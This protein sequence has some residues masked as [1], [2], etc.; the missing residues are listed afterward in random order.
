MPIDSVTPQRGS[1]DAMKSLFR[2]PSLTALAKMNTVSECMWYLFIHQM[3]TGRL[4]GCV[5][6]SVSKVSLD[7]HDDSIRAKLNR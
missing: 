5:Q 4:I 7:P 2:I 6:T 3:L 1:N